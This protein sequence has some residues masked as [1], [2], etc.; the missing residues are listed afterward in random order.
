MKDKHKTIKRIHCNLIDY[1]LGKDNVK[2]IETTSVSTNKTTR[3][4]VTF[5]NDETLFV[6][7]LDHEVEYMK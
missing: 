7:M 6:G 2:S 3:Y 1:E 4:L 5:E